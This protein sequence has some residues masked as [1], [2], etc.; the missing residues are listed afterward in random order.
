MAR[1]EYT[2]KLLISFFSI[3]PLKTEMVNPLLS[4][5]KIS[6][7]VKPSRKA[8][9]INTLKSII[10]PLFH[11]QSCFVHESLVVLHWLEWNQKQIHTYLDHA[12]SYLQSYPHSS[13]LLNRY[14][15]K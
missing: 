13:I 14:Q 11:Q 6:K 12:S 4:V 2:F 7:S 9:S 10:L 15:S 1:I 3:C 8:R 5:V